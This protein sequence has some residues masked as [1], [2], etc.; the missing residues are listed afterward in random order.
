LDNRGLHELLKEVR[1]PERSFEIRE[2]IIN[3]LGYSGSIEALDV[4]YSIAKEME[5]LAGRRL[6]LW[7]ISAV[8]TLLPG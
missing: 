7:A 1:N 4:L 3:A 6:S 5:E 2:R 8:I